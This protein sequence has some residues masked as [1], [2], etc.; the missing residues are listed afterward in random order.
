MGRFWRCP[1]MDAGL[2]RCRGTG[3]I[4]RKS[5]GKEL[6]ERRIIRAYLALYLVPPGDDGDRT[7]SLARFGAYE[8]RLVEVTPD[9]SAEIP[10]LWLE[11]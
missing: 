9:L 6:A 3:T 1:I 5:I 11:L 2:S 7:V 10:L 4:V 8:V